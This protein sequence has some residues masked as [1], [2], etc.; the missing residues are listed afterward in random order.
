[1]K[2]LDDAR[3]ATGLH[4]MLVFHYYWMIYYMQNQTGGA[5]VKPDFPIA[6]AEASVARNGGQD[7]DF[8]RGIPEPVT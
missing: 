4:R 5:Y 2:I 6:Q 3:V 1:M 8:R 7:G